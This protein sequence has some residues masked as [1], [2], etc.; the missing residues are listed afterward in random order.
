MTKVRLSAFVWKLACDKRTGVIALK[1]ALVTGGDSLGINV[2]D[3]EERAFV[4]LNGHLGLDSSPA[5]RD[6]LLA[7][8]QGQPPK[9]II[10]DLTQVSY[11]D[12]S[13]VATLLEALKIA[14]S[15]RGTLCLKGLQGRVERLFEVT[16]L[17]AVFEAACK[18][19]TPESR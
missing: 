8:L 4:G 14:R 13:G 11:I 16:G 5:L 18:A 9:T 2:E 6:R 3:G 17:K 7:I 12:A 10:V 1:R 15:L 19:G